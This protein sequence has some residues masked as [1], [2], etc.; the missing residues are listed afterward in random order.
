[1]IG[2]IEAPSG[3]G[4]GGGSSGGGSGN[5]VFTF[6]Q[7]SMP[8]AGCGWLFESSR[9]SVTGNKG[10]A[11]IGGPGF[12]AKVGRG[13]ATIRF[14][15]PSSVGSV[16]KATL[17]LRF[18]TGEGIANGDFSSV[19]VMGAGGK[20]WKV[21]KASSVK[22][23]GYSKA[24]PNYPVDVTGYVRSVVGSAGGSTGHSSGGSSSG[25]SGANELKGTPEGFGGAEGS[26]SSGVSPGL[27]AS[28]GMRA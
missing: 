23:A 1:M 2:N 4:G 9:L 19:V 7:T 3:G 12:L 8:C 15:V 17:Y 10:S 20:T 13:T 21:L 5:I 28:G 18:D 26:T 24:R 25:S 11:N 14:S 16:S 27:D 6:K 22:A